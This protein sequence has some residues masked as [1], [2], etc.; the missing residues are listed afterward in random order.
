MDAH[1]K[2]A[3][4]IAAAWSLTPAG[5]GAALAQAPAASNAGLIDPTQPP[6]P[7]P[8][9]A[10]PNGETQDLPARQAPRLQMIF[11]GP[12]SRRSA[13]IDGN[14]VRV[15]DQLNAAG[16]P[17]SI[18]RITNHSVVLRHAD[19]TTETLALTAQANQAIVCTR[20]LV[21]QRTGNTQTVS[22]SEA[23]YGETP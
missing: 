23:V 19:Q 1:L 5:A 21:H 11:R 15:G 20:S 18:E 2:V 9:Q 14:I 13:L 4:A 8:M 17:A 10:A 16:Q 3:L 22:C 7:A 6:A 12:G